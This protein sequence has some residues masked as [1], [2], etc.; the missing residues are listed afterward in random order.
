MYGGLF[1]EEIAFFG[2]PYDPNR[3]IRPMSGIPAAEVIYLL[4]VFVLETKGILSKP[5]IS[6]SKK[7]FN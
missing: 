6:K 5:Q 3:G 4:N 2:K 1:N 7:N